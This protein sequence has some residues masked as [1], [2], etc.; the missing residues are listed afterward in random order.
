MTDRASGAAGRGESLTP[1][2]TYAEM[3]PLG[4]LLLP[5]EVPQARTVLPATRQP[6]TR[7]S[8]R[9]IGP[10]FASPQ[11]LPEWSE[12]SNPHTNPMG[13]RNSTVALSCV[14]SLRGWGW[15]G[16]HQAETRVRDHAPR[17]REAGVGHHSPQRA[18]RCCYW[19]SA[20]STRLLQGLSCRKVVVRSLECSRWKI[21]CGPSGLG[22]E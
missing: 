15:K 3:S 22:R 10:T 8:R 19:L 11:L 12:V 6:V 9:C 16:R 20:P 17:G 2:N 21:P 18:R 14:C 1:L 5:S 7:L 4:K 13:R